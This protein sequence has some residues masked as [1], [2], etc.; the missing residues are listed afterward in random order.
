MEVEI[1]GSNICG[2]CRIWQEGYKN[3][4][5]PGTK[6]YLWKLTKEYMVQKL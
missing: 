3:S 5:E 6:F 2:M 1:G 4:G